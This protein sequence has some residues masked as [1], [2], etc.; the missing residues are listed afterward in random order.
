MATSKSISEAVGVRWRGGE[1]RALP[2]CDRAVIGAS[3][4]GG[5]VLP[6]GQSRTAPAI[7][8]PR[9]GRGEPKRRDRMTTPLGRT[10]DPDSALAERTWGPVPTS[11]RGGAVAA[12]TAIPCP[13]L[14]S[15]IERA[16]AL[17]RHRAGEGEARDA[18]VTLA[19]AVYQRRRGEASPA[20]GFAAAPVGRQLLE[21]LRAA[22]LDE[23]TATECGASS[24]LV[25][26]TLRA[27]DGIQAATTP[28]ARDDFASRL[29]GPDSLE[30]LVEV[31]HDLRSP[32][33]SIL[34]LAETLRAGQSGDITDLQ[35]RQLGLIYSAALGLSALASDVTELARG[36]DQLFEE[37]PTP[38]SVNEIFSSVRDIVQPMAEEK[39][40]S[41]ELVPPAADHRVGHA[42]ALSRVLLNLTT[43]ALKFTE[44]GL[45]ELAA[46]E[47]GSSVVEFSVRDTGRGIMPEVLDRLYLPFRPTRGGGSYAFS[48]TG[49]GLAICRRLVKALGSKLEVETRP[50]WGTR[51]FFAVALPPAPHF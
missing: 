34:F 21:L 6:D 35:R 30:L 2:P 7:S 46:R 27:I 17:W 37:E 20:L 50:D 36:G 23:R 51:F 11:A 42:L 31:A 15:A 19:Q 18:L 25:L 5:T 32:L 4:H 28:S 9:P 49:L 33:T 39:H 16:A 41:I 29:S 10:R 24:E 38:L 47:V 3:V 14:R 8:R 12:S 22:A 26:A 43:N 45:V 44:K 40:L 1:F 48:G 13:F